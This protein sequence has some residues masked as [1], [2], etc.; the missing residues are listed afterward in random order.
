M[1]VSPAS[2]L[3]QPMIDTGGTGS[4]HRLPGAHHWLLRGPAGAGQLDGNLG[5][6]EAGRAY[7]GF[8]SCLEDED[9]SLKG[10]MRHRR[11]KLYSVPH[12]RGIQYTRVVIS[13]F[14]IEP[15]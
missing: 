8:P 3:A 7:Q 14:F 13:Q 5:G 10:C 2:Y 1:L 15:R 9:A 11:I 12:R 4:M 6:D